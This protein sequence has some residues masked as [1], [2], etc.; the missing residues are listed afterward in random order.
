MIYSSYVYDTIQILIRKDQKGN[1]FNITEFNKVAKLVNYELY[2]S[3]SSRVEESSDITE[4]LKSFMTMGEE[5]TLTLGV[6]PLPATYERLLGKPYV[7][8]DPA[9]IPVDVITNLELVDR[10]ADELTKPSDAAPIAIIG[11]LETT[12]KIQVYPTDTASIFINYLSLPATPILDY[13]IDQY[14]Q[15]TYLDEGATSISL[16]ALAVYSDGT[17]GPDTIAASLTIDF[18]WHEDQTPILINMILQK[19]GIVLGDQTAI[20]YGIARETKEEQQ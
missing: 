15:Y 8:D 6:E 1:S 19:A 2:N 10:L 5:L 4:A 3:Y 9:F 18:E 12:P 14:G 17:V 20:Q 13:Y 16:P 7:F 11:G